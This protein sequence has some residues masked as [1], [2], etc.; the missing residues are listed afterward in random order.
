MEAFFVGPM[1]RFSHHD[2]VDSSDAPSSSR[3]HFSHFTIPLTAEQS[4]KKKLIEPE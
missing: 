1:S 4:N 3:T 2:A